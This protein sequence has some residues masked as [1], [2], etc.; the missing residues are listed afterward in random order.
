MISRFYRKLNRKRIPKAVRERS[1]VIFQELLDDGYKPGEIAYALDWI[2]DNSKEPVEHFAIVPHMIEQAVE[3]GKKKLEADEAKK[4]VEDE[5]LKA[6]EKRLSEDE[7][8]E[9][10]EDYKEQLS[11]QAREEL[12]E[13]ALLQIR[14]MEGI[15]PDFINDALI[16]AIENQMIRKLKLI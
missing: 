10:L 3:F 11:E 5:R 9:A 8:A 7:E 14:G 2:P 12:R 1:N 13:N 16:K 6:D 4:T 15:K